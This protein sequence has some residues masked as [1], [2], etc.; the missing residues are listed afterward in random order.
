MDGRP[1]LAPPGFEARDREPVGISDGRF[2]VGPDSSRDRPS[3]P[4]LA[5]QDVQL[6]EG[7]LVQVWRIRGFWLEDR[8]GLETALF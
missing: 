8:L 2:W 7:D 4:F 3:K 6:T 1:D 5:D